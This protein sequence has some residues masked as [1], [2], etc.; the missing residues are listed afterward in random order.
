MNLIKEFEVWTLKFEGVLDTPSVFLGFWNKKVQRCYNVGLFV[1]WNVEMRC[2]ASRGRAESH[3]IF[4]MARD[5][6]QHVSTIH[7]APIHLFFG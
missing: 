3:T 6:M 7:S 4:C 2:I 1:L 5:A